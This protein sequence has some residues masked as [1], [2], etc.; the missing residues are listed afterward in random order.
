MQQ[1]E[2]VVLRPP[3]S[4]AARA[5]QEPA[6]CLIATCQT[7]SSTTFLP[8]LLVGA[9]AAVSAFS[10]GPLG[11][12]RDVS[13]RFRCSR[14]PAKAA[15]QLRA[16]LEWRTFDLIVV[17]DELLLRALVDCDDPFAASRWLPVS[18]SDRGAL[19]LVLSKHAFVER[20]SELGI[21]VPESRLAFSVCEAAARAAEIGYPVVLKGDRGFGGLEVGIARDATALK[22]IGLELLAIYPRIL[23]QRH[24]SG[25]RISVCAL[26]QHG[27]LTAYKAYRAECTYPDNQSASTV[28]EFFSHPSI[29]STLQTLGEATGFHG[30]AGVDFMYENER[31]TLYALEINPRPTIGFAGTSAGRDFFSPA[32]ARFLRHDVPAVPAAYDGRE[33]TQSYF[34]G[35][36]FY[37]AST[38]ALHGPRAY[39]RLTAC[40][41]EI[42]LREWR[43]IFWESARFLYDSIGRV[44]RSLSRAPA[45]PR[46]L[47]V[48]M[49]VAPVNREEKHIFP[50]VSPS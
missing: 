5:R 22:R 41:R 33:P 48:A 36:L 29:E 8:A 47:D 32:I 45:L 24:I 21:D 38:G 31:D 18:P 16:L 3:E 15:D 12:G 46:Q 19:E 40:L 25:D 23:V 35:Y 11:L 39:A 20:A 9:G 37:L 43:L 13:E 17:A 2:V 7:W 28:H 30:M 10:P 34:P 1:N 4:F 6:L 27:K 26:Y 44:V 14:E 50:H 42:R 49:V